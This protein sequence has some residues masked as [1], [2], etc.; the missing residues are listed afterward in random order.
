MILDIG[1]VTLVEVAAGAKVCEGYRLLGLGELDGDVLRKLLAK[2]LYKAA[3]IYIVVEELENV[4][5]RAQHVALGIIGALCELKNEQPAVLVDDVEDILLDLGGYFLY[6]VVADTG[7]VVRDVAVR[8]A[9]EERRELLLEEVLAACLHKT[10]QLEGGEVVVLA[11]QH[12]RSLAL[13]AGDSERYQVNEAVLLHVDKVRNGL[14][15]LA[16]AYLREVVL[17]AMV[18]LDLIYYLGLAEVDHGYVERTLRALLLVGGLEVLFLEECEAQVYHVDIV[19]LG[20]G[21]VHKVIVKLLLI[22]LV[23]REHYLGVLELF[24]RK[25][26][27]AHLEHSAVVHN[28]ELVVVRAHLEPVYVREN[29]LGAETESAFAVL[30]LLASADR[31]VIEHLLQREACLVVCELYLTLVEELYHYLDIALVV[32]APEYVLKQLAYDGFARVV[33]YHA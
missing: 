10:S 27:L 25:L 21:H 31:E 16:E 13:C 6:A 9:D 11:H 32:V 8:N 26:Q 19:A 18:V 7:T 12:L 20:G 4:L 23:Q 28:A 14:A 17:V 29:A 24:S 5:C 30:A 3:C 15:V 2:S 22:R 33:A 1:V